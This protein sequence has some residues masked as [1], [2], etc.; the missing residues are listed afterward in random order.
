MLARDIKKDP[1]FFKIIKPHLKHPSKPLNRFLNISTEEEF[2]AKLDTLELEEIKHLPKTNTVL[3]RT[4]EL[5]LGILSTLSLLHF[6]EFISQNKI[7]KDTKIYL[8][9]KYGNIQ[10]EV[11]LSTINLNSLITHE[12]YLL[13]HKESLEL[14][15]LFIGKPAS[16]N[17]L[18]QKTHLDKKVSTFNILRT[19]T[20][21]RRIDIVETIEEPQDFPF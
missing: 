21:L 10:A 5:D 16:P 12:T 6:E 7:P 18:Y 19:L 20:G 2:L 17:L 14:Y 1:L 9:Y 15:E 8:N 13:V 4:T 3:Y 11:P